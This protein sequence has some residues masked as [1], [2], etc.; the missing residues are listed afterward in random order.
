VTVAATAH[1]LVEQP[2]QHRPL[3]ARPLQLSA[4]AHRGRPAAEHLLQQRPDL[5][6]VAALG[7]IGL[8][9]AHEALDHC[10]GVDEVA[11][12]RVEQPVS[13]AEPRRPPPRCA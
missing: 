9:F 7:E 10:R 2:G 8:Q 3:V 1:A 4:L 5:V 6:G 12:D 11:G 13:D